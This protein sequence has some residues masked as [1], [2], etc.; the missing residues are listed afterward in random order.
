MGK[1]IFIEIIKRLFDALIIYLVT[2]TCIYLGWNVFLK[3]A[4]KGILTLPHITFAKSI[5]LNMGLSFV[6][7]GVTYPLA[8]VINKNTNK[9]KD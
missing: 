7:I 6:L 5:L 3:Y 2:T 1:K 9:L 4:L 8:K